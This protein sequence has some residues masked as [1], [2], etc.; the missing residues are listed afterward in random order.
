MYDSPKHEEEVPK[1]I[2]NLIIYNEYMKE[3]FKGKMYVQI[4]NEARRV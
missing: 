3:N 4:P 1:D 2:L